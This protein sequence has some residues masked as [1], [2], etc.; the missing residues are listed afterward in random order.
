MTNGLKQIEDYRG[1]VSDSM[2]EEIQAK[3][4]ELRGSSVVHVNAT[5]YGG[6][7]A[8][9]LDNFVLL[10]NDLGIRTD[11]RVL[12]GVPDFF[13]VTKKFHNA[14]QGA[15]IS[16]SDDELNLYKTINHKFAQFAD[17]SHDYVIIHDPQPAALVEYVE[18]TA[19]WVW[20]CHIDITKP[21]QQAWEFME[22]FIQQAYL[23]Q[24]L[25]PQQ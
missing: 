5:N 6:G 12:H 21:N 13:E 1:I 24:G 19:P 7:V 4:A 16:F 3:A 25:A 9:I 14:L 23:A 2:L 20:R 17:L 11:W 10:M 18:H 15:D 8:E 22:P